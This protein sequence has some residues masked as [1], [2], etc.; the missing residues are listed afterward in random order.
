VRPGDRVAAGQPLFVLD[1]RAAEA[2]VSA[3]EANAV[4]AAA[5]ARAAQVAL[6]DERQRLALFEQVDDPRALSEDE[7]ERRR[8]AV[9]K[10]EAAAAQARAAAASAQAEARV[11]ATDLARLTVHAPIAG[12]VYKVNVRVGEYAAAGVLPEP[13]MTMGTDGLLHV[14]AEFDEA[15]AAR[16]Q[17]G[18]RAYGALRGAPEKRIPLSF[19]R[20]EPAVSE[21]R[22]LSGGA[23]RVDTRVVE[24]IYAFDPAEAGAFIGQRMDVFVA[25]PL[26]VT[27]QAKSSGGRS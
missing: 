5:A 19:V 2:A 27:A 8:F 3:A 12:R 4:S 9:R 10:A 7:L 20:Y 15:D 26:A 16:L 11:R 22:A 6:A 13:L 1:R 24:A 23:E 18:A 21:K 25:A 14:R 17:P